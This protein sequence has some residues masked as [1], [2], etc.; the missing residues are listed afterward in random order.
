MHDQ[1]WQ[2]PFLQLLQRPG[3]PQRSGRCS[4]RRLCSSA[5]SSSSSRVLPLM[6]TP[7]KLLVQG[8]WQRWQ[9]R[10]RQP[11]PGQP[12]RHMGLGSQAR[13]QIS[14]RSAGGDAGVLDA[15]S[16]AQ[17]D[18]EQDMELS[19]DL[20]ALAAALRKFDDQL[21]AARSEV[22]LTSTGLLSWSRRG[23]TQWMICAWTVLRVL[24]GGNKAVNTGLCMA[25]R[26]LLLLSS[27]PQ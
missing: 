2:A 1:L 3:L 10:C 13:H 15:A 9:A 5:S 4:S 24:C 25:K 8:R 6:D 21:E 7:L 26:N 27:R 20:Q 14:S 11:V 16:L 19:G 17:G 23:H 12:E 22:Y 18:P